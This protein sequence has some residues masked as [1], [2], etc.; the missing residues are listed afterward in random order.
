MM[1]A[2]LL[3]AGCMSRCSCHRKGTGQELLGR[4]LSGDPCMGYL[5]VMWYWCGMACRRMHCTGQDACSFCMSAW[6]FPRVS[7]FGSPNCAWQQHLAT[8]S[9]LALRGA[10]FR[11]VFPVP[12]CDRITRILQ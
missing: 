9:D 3:L 7:V 5:D 12:Q 11:V 4:V 10:R 6:C 1:G 2:L 8:F